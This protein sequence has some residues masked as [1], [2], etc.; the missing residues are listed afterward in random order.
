M[1]LRLKKSTTIVGLCLMALGLFV[2]FG[3]AAISTKSAR[4]QSEGGRLITVHDRGTQT[5]FITTKDTLKEALAD[6][7]IQLHDHDTVEP[8][9]DE[10]LV[11]PDYQVNIYRARPVTVV[12]GATRQK[13]ITPYQT[14][15]RIAKDAGITL[16]AEDETTLTRSIDIV[17]DGAGL[18]LTI[19]R[20]TPL[21]L[22][23]YG[24]KTTIRTQGETVG[25]M[26][27]EKNI[28]LGERGRTS[29][30]LETPVRSGM[31]VR[32]WREGKQTVTVDEAIAYETKQIKDADREIGYKKVQT[33]GKDGKRT[34]TY[35]IEIKNGVEVERTEI[36]SIVLEQAVKQVEIIGSKPKTIP[37]TGGGSKTEWLAASNIPEAYWGYADF[38]V[39]KE[40]SWNPNA[41]N[42]SS[43]ACGLAQALP[44]SKL[45]PNWSNPVVALNW[46]NNY[47]NGRYGNWENAYSFWLRN[48]WY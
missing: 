13:I 9:V 3:I 18:Q 45:G 22:D 20:A 43:G 46:M 40:S 31:K 44:C 16:H 2:V 27:K 7:G 48:H 42:R 41:V 6:Q 32:V 34:V 30:S 39:Q 47:V 37:Y 24:K 21:T 8:S 29:V 12:D 15:E 19:D 35:E 5:A 25:E 10:K 14:A 38:M 4:A 23:L 33:A 11:A 26:L 1:K 36:A 17:G 28:E